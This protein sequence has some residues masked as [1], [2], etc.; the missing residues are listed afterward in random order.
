MRPFVSGA[1]DTVHKFQRKSGS[2][3]EAGPGSASP[4]NRVQMQPRVAA[5]AFLPRRGGAG[6]ESF[7]LVTQKKIQP[8]P[9]PVLLGIECGGTRTVALLVHGHEVLRHEAGPANLRLVTDRQLLRHFRA[10]R[11]RLNISPDAIGIGMAGARTAALQKRILVAAGKVWP[12][13]PCRATSDLETALAA[14][15]AA[16]RTHQVLILSGTGSCCF[17]RDAGGRT[18]QFGGWGHLLGD[19]G[20]GYEIG[21]RAGPA[22]STDAPVERAERT[23]RLGAGGGQD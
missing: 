14:A 19:K 16:G 13:V 17:G 23:D 18:F 6:T 21:L 5:P 9:A 11:K 12:G 3:R 1:L 22:D 7:P 8:P 2:T 20:S 10:L 15:P 4:K